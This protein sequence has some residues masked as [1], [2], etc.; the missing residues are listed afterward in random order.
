MHNN[1]KIA[2]HLRWQVQRGSD[3]RCVKNRTASRF[4]ELSRQTKICRQSL[5]DIV[6]IVANLSDQGR[7]TGIRLTA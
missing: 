7:L 3:D 6:S 2:V 1:I 5:C 4:L